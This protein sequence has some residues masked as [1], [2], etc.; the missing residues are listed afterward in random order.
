MKRRDFVKL[1]TLLSAGTALPFSLASALNFPDKDKVYTIGILG[2][3]DRGSGLHQVLNNM[4][5]QFQVQGICD[6]LPLRLEAAKKKYPSGIQFHEDYRSLLDQKDLDVILVST[7]L[8]L[9]F[10]HAKAVLESGKDLFLEKTMVFTI[11]QAIELDKLSKKYP[12]QTIQIGHQYRYSPLYFKVKE[13]IQDGWLGKVTQVEARWDRNHN[14]R[15]PL[16]SPDLERQ[17]NWRMYKEYSG[18]LVAELLSHQMDFIHW[19]FETNP[20]SVY[21]VGG[22]DHFRDGRETYDNVQVTLRYDK[23]G[24]VGNFGA[25]CSNQY[26][27]YSFKIKGSK[28][29][30]SLLTNEGVFYPE[31]EVKA[32]LEQVDGVSGATRLAWSADKRGVKILNEPT[33]DGSYYALEDFYR[34]LLTKELPHSNVGN[35]GRSAIVVALAN[36]SLY[37]GEK[38]LWKPEFDL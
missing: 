23:E 16:P 31:P 32:E 35:G 11:D 6:N 36:Q 13:M 14:W 4:P 17:I 38:R 8:Y 34:C 37:S 29:M 3:G 24:M 1:G 22:I 27:G 7:P 26:D 5:D 21:G 2:Y 12:K 15:R 9:H 25:T 19:A 28:G 18:G 10:E 33:R 20:S 30:V